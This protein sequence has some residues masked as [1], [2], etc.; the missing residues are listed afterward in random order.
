MLKKITEGNSELYGVYYTVFGSLAG[1]DR[2]VKEY[3]W[4][5][6]YPDLKTA[7]E[8]ARE[9]RDSHQDDD[10]FVVRKY[11]PENSSK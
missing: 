4:D 1:S 8:K 9:L 2:L 3:F 7:V 10:S 5:G 6:P 11:V